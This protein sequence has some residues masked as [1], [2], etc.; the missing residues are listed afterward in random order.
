[1]FQFTPSTLGRKTYN[2]KYALYSSVVVINVT[3]LSVID[4]Y[5]VRCNDFLKTSNFHMTF[6]SGFFTKIKKNIT[7]RK[8][9]LLVYET[10]SHIGV[11]KRTYYN[12]SDEQ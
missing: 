5:S 11:V 2:S 4:R 10:Q 12:F 6:R 1:M 3:S 9:S 8:K 7:K